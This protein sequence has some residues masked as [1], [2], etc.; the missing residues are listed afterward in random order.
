M[1][2]DYGVGL[3]KHHLL[4]E[5]VAEGLIEK[6]GQ[7]FYYRGPNQDYK[8]G[9]ILSAVPKTVRFSED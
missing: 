5:L 4:S 3:L 9:M 2:A 1:S 8:I 6:E 7:D